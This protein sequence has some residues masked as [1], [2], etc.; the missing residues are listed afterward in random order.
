MRM[1]VC[2]M[3][4]SIQKRPTRDSFLAC[5]LSDYVCGMYSEGKLIIAAADVPDNQHWS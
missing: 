3:C 1:R 4:L 5:Y 2:R